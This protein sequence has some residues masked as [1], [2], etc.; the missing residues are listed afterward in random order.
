M[1]GVMSVL[2]AVRVVLSIFFDEI[3]AQ[4]FRMQ[5]VDDT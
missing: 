5:D 3:E 4:P 2:E 1:A